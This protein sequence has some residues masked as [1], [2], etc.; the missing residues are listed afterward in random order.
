MKYI[1]D[2]C[3]L[4]ALL[5]NETGADRVAELLNQS[6]RGEQTVLMHKAN[7]L[8]VYY[9][10]YRLYG[11]LK[12]DEIINEVKEQAITVIPDISD[13]LFTCAGRIKSKYKISF[14]DTFA[15]AAAEITG[16]T[17]LTSDHHEMDIIEKTKQA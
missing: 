10:I 9:D 1:L 11:K 14:A 6:N 3:A 13:E 16:A 8:E 12:A 2:A 4:L 15:L 17:L 7:L 5:R